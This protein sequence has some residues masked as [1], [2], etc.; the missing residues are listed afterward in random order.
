VKRLLW[1]LAC[2]PALAQSTDAVVPGPSLPPNVILKLGGLAE[3]PQGSAFRGKLTWAADSAL[4]LFISGERS[5]LPS[6]SQAP[7]VNGSATI[8]TTASLGGEYA[9]G[10]FSLGLQY[11]HSEMSDLLVSRRYYLQ[12]ALELGPWRLGVEVSTRSTDFDRLRFS[13]LTINTP[14]GPVTVTGYADLSLHDTGFGANCEYDGDIWRPYA[15]YTHYS[16]GS[17][18]GNTD[19]T[20][21]RNANGIVSP[22]VFQALSGRLAGRLERLAS[23]R[24]NRK[25][26]LLDAA[27]TLGLE[28]DLTRTRWGIEINQDVDHLT[29]SL[30]NT[31]TGTLG[32]KATPRFTV[33][34]QV[35]ATRSDAFGTDRFAGL[36]FVLRTRPRSRF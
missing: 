7:S 3:S 13:G 20:R 16:F 2:L 21:I 12:P 10:A 24:L 4:T 6:T 34:F 19:V 18:T 25:A 8:T 35:G 27:A 26:A 30:S 31:G 17:F 28:A 29:G 32:W 22:E 9:F 11:D 1:A 5:N 23:T 36:A 15:S 33:E 14:T